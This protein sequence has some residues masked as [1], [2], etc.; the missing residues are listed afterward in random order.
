MTLRVL[1]KV[2][3]AAIGNAAGRG[4]D[5]PPNKAVSSRSSSVPWVGQIKLPNWVKCSLRSV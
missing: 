3:E 5:E 2:G 4:R 1:V